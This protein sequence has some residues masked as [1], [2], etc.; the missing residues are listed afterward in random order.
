[1]DLKFFRRAIEEL[2]TRSQGNV[3][4]NAL[5]D[6]YIEFVKEFV[7]AIDKRFKDVQRWDIE[8]LDEAVDAISDK[9]GK[10]AKVYEIWDEIWDAKIEKRVVKVEIIKAF[11]NIIDLAERKYGGKEANK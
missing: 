9:L 1:M 6:I 10:S 7:K 4:A 3:N 8:V 11:L 5:Y 2:L